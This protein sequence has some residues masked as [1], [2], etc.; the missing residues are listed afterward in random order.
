MAH[1]GLLP[2]LRSQQQGE[3]LALLTEIAARVGA[4]HCSVY[5][6]IQRAEQVGITGAL[7]AI[8]S[9]VGVARDRPSHL[10]DRHGTRPARADGPETSRCHARPVVTAC[11]RR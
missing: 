7:T 2:I 8:T 10:P 9:T 3:I 11:S 4:P 1:P 5:R 6:E